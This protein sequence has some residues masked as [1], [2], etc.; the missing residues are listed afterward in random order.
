MTYGKP[1]ELLR[2]IIGNRP[3]P[4]NDLGH[5]PLDDFDHFCAYSGCDPNDAWAKLAYVTASLSER[6]KSVSLLDEE[7]Q[8]QC[9]DIAM[10]L[11]DH[12]PGTTADIAEYCVLFWDGDRLVGAHLSSDEPGVV[13]EPFDIDDV[14]PDIPEAIADWLASPTFTFRPSL[15][16]WLKDA[17]PRESGV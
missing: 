10:L 13:D 17:P 15:L 5:T 1:D 2:L 16:E 4:K 14:L 8:R 9:A 7:M 11:R 12:S 3:L 6:R